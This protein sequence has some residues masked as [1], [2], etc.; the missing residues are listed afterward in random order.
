MLF[1]L[2][3]FGVGFLNVIVFFFL[4]WFECEWIFILLGLI[5]CVM[6]K[7][8]RVKELFFLFN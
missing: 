2:V 6:G 3:I 5:K 1:I 4:K 7:G 8:I